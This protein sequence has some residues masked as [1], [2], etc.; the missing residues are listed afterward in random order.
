MRAREKEVTGMS[1]RDHQSR[2]GCRRYVH[3]WFRARDRRG[4]HG[5]RT[6]CQRPA[7]KGKVA[8]KET[9]ALRVSPPPGFSRCSCCKRRVQTY[10]VVVNV[11]ALELEVG[12]TLVPAR[13]KKQRFSLVS[14][15]PPAHRQRA[16]R[17]PSLLL[18]VLSGVV[19][20]CVEEKSQ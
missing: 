14:R 3:P 10:L 11:D 9:R 15:T 5:G 18:N 19:D 17:G 8:R 12:G 20:A 6:C 4:R 13:R 16:L 1:E 7:R 2:I